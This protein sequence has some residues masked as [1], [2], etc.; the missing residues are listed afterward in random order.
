MYI[1]IY[2]YIY[3]YAH[4]GVVS[5][6]VAQRDGLDQALEG[7]AHLL[8]G[9][10]AVHP[11]NTPGKRHRRIVPHLR[12]GYRSRFSPLSCT[13]RFSPLSRFSPYRSCSSPSSHFSPH[14]SR[15]SPI[16]R[17]RF[18]PHKQI[19]IQSKRNLWENPVRERR[20]AP[21]RSRCA[22]Q[23]WSGPAPPQH[24]PA[25]SGF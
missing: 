3:I 7:R 1:Y 11:R 2:I 14:R 10:R 8:R 22:A 16:H 25:L 5:R 23:R 21:G 20:A 18:S 13:S 24:C 12:K 9:G 4:L 6:V 19:A 15:F 17:S